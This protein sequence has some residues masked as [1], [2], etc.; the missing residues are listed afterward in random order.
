M[1][2]QDVYLDHLSNHIMD[3]IP[4]DKISRFCVLFGKHIMADFASLG[5]A[6]AFRSS[7]PNLLFA[8]YIPQEFF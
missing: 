3:I 6:I 4:K 1:D 2:Q 5:E 8:I 7:H